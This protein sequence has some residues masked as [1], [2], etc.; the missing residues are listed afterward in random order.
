MKR[1]LSLSETCG[2]GDREIIAEPD[3]RCGHAG[4]PPGTSGSLLE[5]PLAVEQVHQLLRSRGRVRLALL[6]RLVL[7][8][9]AK[10]AELARLLDRRG[11][12]GFQIELEL[13]EFRLEL[14]VRRAGH[15]RM[16]RL[17]ILDALSLEERLRRRAPACLVRLRHLRVSG[18]AEEF[19]HRLEP[20]LA[21]APVEDGA[22]QGLGRFLVERLLLD[23]APQGPFRPQEVEET[24][25]HPGS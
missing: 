3:A 2:W 24:L 10:V 9:L 17:E 22:L 16:A 1:L 25:R 23:Q 12:H 21:P 15:D 7:R 5:E 20:P 4:A 19:Q 13:L 14:L 8:V 6:R 18:A 11:D